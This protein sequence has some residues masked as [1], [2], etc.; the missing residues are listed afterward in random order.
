M[1]TTTTTTTT[2][3]ATTFS[4]SDI[5]NPIIGSALYNSNSNNSN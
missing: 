1:T 4:S 2:T 5:S 3:T